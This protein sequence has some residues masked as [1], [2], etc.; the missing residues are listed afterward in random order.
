MQ[1]ALFF[2]RK[3]SYPENV[4]KDTEDAY[5][6]L[7]TLLKKTTYAAGDEVTVADFCWITSVTTLKF[8]LPVDERKWPHLAAWVERI[9][10]LPCYTVNESGL[11]QYKQYASEQLNQ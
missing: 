9:K 2:E 10:K 1:R 11:K 7:D 5:T 4:L 6:L 8:Y 3:N